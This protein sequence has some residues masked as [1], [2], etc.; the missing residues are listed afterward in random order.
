MSKRFRASQAKPGELK[1]QW[2]K[3]PGE[4]PD[5]CTV[6]GDG[7]GG[8]GRDSNLL[9]DALCNPR[10]RY[11]SPE[12]DKSVIKRLE[13]RGYDITTLRFSIQKKAVKPT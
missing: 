5:I 6:W 9:M 7:A 10:N 3:L 2:G 1:M 11:M 13:E 12:Q 8:N 4:N